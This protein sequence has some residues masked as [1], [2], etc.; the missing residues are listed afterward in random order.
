MKKQSLNLD[1]VRDNLAK[2]KKLEET[3]L[4]KTKGGKI[5][6]KVLTGYYAE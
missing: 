4:K 2:I 6:F 1:S 3:E 5:P